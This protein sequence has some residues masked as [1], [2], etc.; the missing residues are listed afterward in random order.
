M[1]ER[2][3][4]NQEE[5]EISKSYLNGKSL[6]DLAKEKNSSVCAISGA[7]RRQKTSTRSQ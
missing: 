2:I 7:L 4:T 5:F 6:G 3:F 1:A